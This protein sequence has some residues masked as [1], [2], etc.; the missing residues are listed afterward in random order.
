MPKA[1][2]DH[3][4]AE[5]RLPAFGVGGPTL[6]A[7]PTYITIAYFGQDIRVLDDGEVLMMD[8]EEFLEDAVALAENDPMAAA[9]IR[10]LLR[11]IVHPEDFNMFWQTARRNRQGFEDQMS[12][13]KVVIE[14]MTGRPTVLPSVSSSGRQD[15]EPKYVGDSSSKVRR[16]LESRGRPDLALAVVLAQ[17]GMERATG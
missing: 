9:L 8:L 17:E 4:S 13:A 11:R 5:R 15:T 1:P 12:F 10:R 3:K 16:R 14:A 6:V 2:Q 7:E